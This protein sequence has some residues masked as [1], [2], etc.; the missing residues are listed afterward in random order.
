MVRQRKRTNSKQYLFCLVCFL[1]LFAGCATKND[2][3]IESHIGLGSI[4]KDAIDNFLAS[5]ME[6]LK[7]P[8]LSIAVINKGKVVHQK[9]MGYADVEE[10]LPITR[11]TIFEG[12]SLSKSVFA[13]FVMTYVEEGRLSLDKPLYEYLPYDDID[14]DD[15]YKKITARMVLS[16]RSGFPNWRRDEADGNLKI[17]FEPG[18]Q[19]HYSGEGYQY[20]AMVLRHIEGTDWAGLEAAFQ[21]RV[22]KPLG[23]ENTVFIQTPYT[24]EYKA[25]AYDEEGKRIGGIDNSEFGA[26]YS[27]HSESIDFSKWMIAVM[28]QE[29]LSKE[30]YAELLKSHA[31]VPSGIFDIT[32]CLGFFRPHFPMIDPDIYFHTGNNDGF[33][34]WYALDIKKDWGFVLFTN[35]PFGEALGEE[36]FFHLLLG[37]YSRVVGIVT[38]L[39]ILIGLGFLMR[40]VIHKVQNRQRVA[41]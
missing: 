39:T 1:F 25:Q 30:S 18:T 13:F 29:H 21:N 4:S 20:L 2:D 10:K 5:K 17:K 41:L 23:L 15:R 8:G 9:T 35:S 37:P 12:A 31:T 34:C 19:Y 32:Y 11:E 28:D 33:T 38:V 22:A 6:K 7:I 3:D 16:H 14:H 24:R 36:L 40:W 27:I 26:G